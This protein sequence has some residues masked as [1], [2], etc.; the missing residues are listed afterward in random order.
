MARGAEQFGRFLARLVTRGQ[1][2]KALETAQ[3]RGLAK[4]VAAERGPGFFITS[5]RVNALENVTF[6]NEKGRL[7]TVSLRDLMPF[8]SEVMAILDKGK[9]VSRREFMAMVKRDLQRVRGRRQV[10]KAMRKAGVT[11]QDALWEFSERIEQRTTDRF[12]DWMLGKAGVG[13]GKAV[14]RIPEIRANPKAFLGPGEKLP[15]RRDADE[16]YTS[17]LKQVEKRLLAIGGAVAGGTLGSA[18]GSRRGE[19]A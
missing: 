14:G 18:V 10:L 9:K 1:G 15:I 5:P 12:M 6:T 7:A 2:R 16:I 13:G 19:A 3:S 4:K 8:K 17:L 11:P